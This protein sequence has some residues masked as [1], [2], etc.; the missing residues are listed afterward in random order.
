MLRTLIA[1]C[2]LALLVSPAMGQIAGS[3]EADLEIIGPLFEAGDGARV[4]SLAD[5][6]EK[7]SRLP[8]EA[9]VMVQPEFFRADM[10]GPLASRRFHTVYFDVPRQIGTPVLDYSA[11]TVARVKSVTL[12]DPR[13]RLA[14]TTT[15]E[16]SNDV[17]VALFGKAGHLRNYLVRLDPGQPLSLSTGSLA[18]VSS[19]AFLAFQPFTADVG[20]FDHGTKVQ[21]ENF[22]S[23]APQR[24]PTAD[25][26]FNK[27][28]TY[29][30]NADEEIRI[31]AD[32]TG[33]YV[34]GRGVREET[35]TTNVYSLNIEYPAG[36]T[37]HAWTSTT[38]SVGD[39]A[40][41]ASK[42]ETERVTDTSITH[43][44]FGMDDLLLYCG[45]VAGTAECLTG[46]SETFTI[47]LAGASLGLCF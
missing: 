42:Y 46:C 30:R 43:A 36:V 16:D 34:Y 8:P 47:F 37:F 4:A 45:P 22:A 10:T 25:R 27:V 40:C 38:Y 41:K 21:E 29:C 6:G 12:K 13:L 17:T 9:D 33:G 15:A 39:P 26:V 44:W 3:E 28:R 11:G 23:M 2:L 32:S 18:G 14:L 1:T 19:I 5:F 20:T 7:G 35:T 24:G 31:V